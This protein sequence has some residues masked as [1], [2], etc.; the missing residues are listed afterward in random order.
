MKTKINLLL[1]AFCIM[2]SATA[3]AQISF[4]TSWSSKGNKN[5]DKDTESKTSNSKIKTFPNFGTEKARLKEYHDEY[6]YLGSYL[7]EYTAPANDYKK[8]LLF[9]DSL[10]ENYDGYWGP[11]SS[12]GDL[13]CL[14]N[15]YKETVQKVSEFENI[16][17]TNYSNASDL[18]T[19]ELETMLTNAGKFKTAKTDT[20]YWNNQ[21]GGYYN[22]VV[23]Y[24]A[25]LKM[26]NGEEN[27]AAKA[28]EA[29]MAD[30]KTQI[31]LLKKETKAT[32]DADYATAQA[33]IKED[34]AKEELLKLESSECPADVYTGSDKE[35]LRAAII[36][37]WST[38]VE[39]C[40]KSW[41]ILKVIF[42]DNDWYHEKGQEWNSSYTSLQN[43][44]NS[45]LWVVVV[46]QPK[47]TDK[48]DVAYKIGYNL[49]KDFMNGGK[50][51]YI[52]F[53]CADMKD[54]PI[55]VKNVK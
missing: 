13:I 25:A 42:T 27:A 35:T 47:N 7:N 54:L 50:I 36:Q 21:L 44:D 10:N 15:V 41:K 29:K 19:K 53:D 23:F 12:N 3:G 1:L 4:Q 28:L 22:D 5:K 46:A 37:A 30:T 17:K 55:L 39:E 11:T 49:F 32:I 33:K 45:T 18:G 20:S 14:Y 38:D 8:V 31:A 26:L 40:G 52:D 2:L 24:I 6:Y 48:P 34:A 16:I 51:S 9:L 43:Y